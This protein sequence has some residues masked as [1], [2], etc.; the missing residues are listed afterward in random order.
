MSFTNST[1]FVGPFGCALPGFVPNYNPALAHTFAPNIGPN[2]SHIDTQRFAPTFGPNTPNAA[3][4][5]HGFVPSPVPASFGNS[6]SPIGW[7]PTPWFTNPASFNNFGWASPTFSNNSF[8][9]NDPTWF[10]NFNANSPAWFSHFAPTS[11][12]NEFPS[13]LSAA[14]VSWPAYGWNQSN[15]FSPWTPS[16]VPPS[17]ASP[18]S[19]SPTF[20]Q[21]TNPAQFQAFTPWFSPALGGSPWFAPHNWTNAQANP[22]LAQPGTTTPNNGHPTPYAVATPPNATAARDAA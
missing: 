18:W 15:L 17:N 7:N 14:Q 10:N 20:Y 4:P 13:T 21:P 22:T 5:F 11:G 16:F 19:N 1:P 2:F 3:T 12:T 9:P 8:A 6:P